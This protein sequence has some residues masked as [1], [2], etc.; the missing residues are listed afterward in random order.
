MATDDLV[1]TEGTELTLE[2]T[3]ASTADAVFTQA[4]DDTVATTDNAGYPYLDFELQATWATSTGIEDGEVRLY[5]R[6]L[7]FEGTSD[8]PV[9]D[10]T[11]PRRH[12]GSFFPDAVTSSQNLVL[13]G[14]P[15]SR[16][17][18]EYYI[19][20]ATGQTISAA[21]TLKATPWTYG[22]SA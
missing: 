7:N 12:V 1:F 3:G 19:E 10:A 22:P 20:N 13:E 6:L 9:P 5:E 21:W 4:D 11:Y 8:E 15:R 18:A 2:A 14:V 17:E 16:R